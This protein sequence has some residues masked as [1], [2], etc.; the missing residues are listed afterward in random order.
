MPRSLGESVEERA[1]EA[2]DGF[3]TPGPNIPEGLDLD[4]LPNIAVPV[5]EYIKPGATGQE[6]RRND[7]RF[8]FRSRLGDLLNIEIGT[9]VEGIQGVVN[10]LNATDLESL[11]RTGLNRVIAQ[12]NIAQANSLMGIFEAQVTNSIIQNDIATAVEPSV[13]VS[14]SG[15]NGIEDPNTPQPVIPRSDDAE[16]PVRN[17]HI[18]ASQSNDTKI[19]FGDD[20]VVPEDGFV[21]DQGESR[22]ISLDF[23][24]SAL[25]M[26]S[27]Q[28]SQEV[29]L[30]GLF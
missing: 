4:K 29:Q 13:G 18:K 10:E 27:T 24:N 15:T 8:D 7:I 11:D 30:L 21:L 26:A 23:R 20:E 12:A 19:W 25:W 14:V 22:T 3:R 17:L 16:I 5:P 1:K 6:E 9:S 2:K 28:E